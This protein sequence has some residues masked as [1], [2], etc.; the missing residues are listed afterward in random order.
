MQNVETSLRSLYVTFNNG[1][2]KK[3]ITTDWG[4]TLTKIRQAMSVKG[5][6]E[7][8]ATNGNIIILDCNQVSAITVKTM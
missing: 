2:E 8:T 5:V 3:Y 4:D 7:F 1:K 6:L